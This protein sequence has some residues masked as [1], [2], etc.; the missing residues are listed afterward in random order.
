[1]TTNGKCAKAP[2]EGT[3]PTG[4]ATQLPATFRLHSGQHFLSPGLNHEYVGFEEIADS[5]W[6]IV[7][8]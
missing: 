5:L 3:V 7:Y 1:M 8:Y 4:G 6:G 2:P